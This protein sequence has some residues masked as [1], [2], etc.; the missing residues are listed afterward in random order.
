[1]MNGDLMI[2]LESLWDHFGMTLGSFWG[3]SGII[4]GSFWDHF[5]I[6]RGS[7]GLHSGVIWTSFWDHF[8]V[9]RR[10]FGGH[11]EVILGSFSGIWSWSPNSD[12]TDPLGVETY[13]EIE[14]FNRG[15]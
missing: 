7:F 9:I 5:G 15:S 11:L 6:N 10:S 2:I 4:L 13:V 1:M 14:F 12:Y 8:G 3:Y